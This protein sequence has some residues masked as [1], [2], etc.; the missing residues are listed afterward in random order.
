MAHPLTKYRFQEA[1]LGLPEVQ[2]FT[3]GPNR[4]DEEVAAWIKAAEGDNSVL[5]DIKQFGIEVWLYR[6]GEGELVGFSSLGENT[7]S[8]PLP[9][10][11]KHRISYIPVI[12]VHERF[13]G[14]P[15]DAERDDKFAYQILDDLI[16]YTAEKTASR[17]DLYP[18]IGLS[19]DQ[20]NTRAI[21]FYQNRGFVDA[22][23]PRT[24]KTTG[25]VY[26]RMFLNIE[27]L[28]HSYRSPG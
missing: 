18:V 2:S 6:T 23:S 8:F 24:D 13:Q 11:P 28:V 15:K 5:E 20:D 7:W 9:K 1:D 10:G 3:C 22:R 19:V 25:I 12:G 17:P 4:W 14:E 21:R 27:E 26:M 16:E